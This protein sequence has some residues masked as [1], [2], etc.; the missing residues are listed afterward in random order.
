MKPKQTWSRCC[1][2]LGELKCFCL[3]P[4]STTQLLS[5]L[6]ILQPSISLLPILTSLAESPPAGDPAEQVRL[7]LVGGRGQA[8][9]SSVSSHL[10]GG[11]PVQ[12]Q[13]GQVVVVG[14]IVVVLMEVDALNSRHLFGRAAAVQQEF[15]QVDGPHRGRVETAGDKVTSVTGAVS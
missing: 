6:Q 11:G 3:P 1:R 2:P 12:L 15:T 8:G 7:Q 4:R 10:K 13:Q 14:V 9:G 5:S